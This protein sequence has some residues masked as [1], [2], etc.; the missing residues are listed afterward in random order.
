M[1]LPCPWVAQVRPER[2]KLEYEAAVA[3]KLPELEIGGGGCVR[4]RGL[5]IAHEKAH[6]SCD[7]Y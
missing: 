4:E 5:R 3:W 6:A 1:E 7:L 2:L